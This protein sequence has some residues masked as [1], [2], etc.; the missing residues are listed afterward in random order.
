MKTDDAATLTTDHEQLRQAFAVFSQASTQLSGVYREL[1]QQV[2]RLTGELAVANG[3]LQREL[4]AKEALSQQLSQLLTAL[5]GG[6]V[7]LDAAERIE[8]VNP[9][10]VRLLGQPLLGMPWRQI[11]DERLGL[12]GVCGEWYTGMGDPAGLRRVR[13]ESSQSATSSERILLIHDITETHAMQ[14]RALRHQRLAEMGEMA[15][16]LA[17]QLRT[18]LSTALLYAGHLS[19]ETLP[20]QER[21]GLAA[22]TIERLHHLEQLIR[23]MLQFVKGETAPAGQVAL[24]TLLNELQRAL[25]PQMQ[26]RGLQF[27]VEDHSRGVNL[28]VNHEALCSALTNLL[29]NAMQASLPGGRI[30]LACTAG[31]DEVVLSVSDDGPGIDTALQARLFEPFFTT[32]TEG[33]GLGLAIVHNVIRAL[34]GDIEVESAPGAGSRFTVR[35]PRTLQAEVVAGAVQLS[36]NKRS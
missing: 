13:I 30:T 3:E 2:S 26:Q 12:A 19:N 1:Q 6:V 27:R 34:N 28:H 16:G 10:A 9:A 22:K 33:T 7:A 21:R 35:L 25:A 32:R 36:N 4:A 14:A 23:N 11:A 29:D 15:A 5:P 20:A 31:E 18:P 24:P 8:R 17:H